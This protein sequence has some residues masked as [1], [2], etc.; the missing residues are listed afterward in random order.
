MHLTENIISRFES[1]YQKGD[2][3]SCWVWQGPK[4]PRGYGNFD[5]HLCERDSARKTHSAHR[6][7]WMIA[8]KQ[9]I[10][11]GKMICHKCDNPQ[12]VNPNHLYL[13]TGFDNNMD[14]VNRGRAIRKTGES[15]SWAKLTEQD[16]SDIRKSTESQAT[17]ARYYGV[18]P[19]HVSRLKSGD[20]NPWMSAKA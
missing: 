15:C 9:E 19:S 8:N 1:K 10:P 18:S 13:G 6:I 2:K 3:D 14:T 16:V 4:Q 12:C 7:A 17:L 11:P 20:R 5:L